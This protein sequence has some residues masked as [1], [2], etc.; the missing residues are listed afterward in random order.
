MDEATTLTK[1]KF[2]AVLLSVWS[3]P[4]AP[5]P[6]M[7]EPKQYAGMKALLAFEGRDRRRLKREWN[8]AWRA[9]RKRELASPEFRSRQSQPL[10][11]SFQFWRQQ[12]ATGQATGP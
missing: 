2:D 5:D 8:K 12:P 7:M 10:P 1:A 6:I 4:K 11:G 3:K 9:A